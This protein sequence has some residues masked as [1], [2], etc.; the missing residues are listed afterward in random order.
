MRTLIIIITVVAVIITLMAFINMS[1]SNTENQ[2]YDILGKK[3]EVEFRYYPPVAMATVQFNA[4]KY[5]ELSS[6]GFRKLAGYIF[7]GNENETKIAMTSP[8]HMNMN[9][10]SSS[11]SFVMPSNYQLEELPQPDDRSVKL[12]K[13]NEE[14]VACISFSGYADD[15]KIEKYKTILSN[16]L[17]SLNITH[18]ND[19]RYL[20]YNP[21]YQVI[22][23]KN[24]IIVGINKEEIPVNAVN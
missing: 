4:L 12:S 20:G 5:K 11:M 23:R 3:G 21:P 14:Y 7:G 24:E 8:V 18:N 10:S 17:N 19:F 15:E 9:D 6:P 13:S 22:G 1:T 16:E 2:P